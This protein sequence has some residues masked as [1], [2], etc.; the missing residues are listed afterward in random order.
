MTNTSQTATSVAID[1]K[2]LVKISSELEVAFCALSSDL[3]EEAITRLS[4]FLDATPNADEVEKGYACEAV[5]RL[6][7]SARIAQNSI[8]HVYKSLN[9][10]EV[11]Q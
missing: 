9:G 4:A 2:N 6:Y 1:Q 10:E 7:T 3:C 5:M 8:G 11:P